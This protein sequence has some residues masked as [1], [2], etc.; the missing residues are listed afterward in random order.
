MIIGID[1]DNTLIDYRN[2]FWFTALETGTLLESERE[3]ITENGNPIPSKN[4]IKK[5][6]LSH[7]N[8]NYKWEYLQGQVY[9]NNIHHAQI[10]PGVANFLLHC[11]RRGEKVFLISHKTEY[12]H[13]DKNKTSL[14][15]A[16]LNFL[17]TNYLFSDAF[18][19]TR[20]DIFFFDTRQKKVNKIAELNCDYFID[21]LSEVFEE[22][23]F[24]TGTK[25]ILFNIGSEQSADSSFN[26]WFKIN[27]FFFKRIVPADVSAYVK[28][29]INKD[30]K[31]IKKIKG[32]GN[33]SIFRIE[34]KSGERY[35]GKLYPDPTFDNRKRLEN[36]AKA[37]KFLH[38]NNINSVPQVIWTDDNLN[39]G[40]YEW[41]HGSEIKNISKSNISNAVAFVKSLADLSKKTRYEEFGLASAACISGKMIQ[42]QIH[43]RYKKISGFSHLYPALKDFLENELYTSIKTILKFSQKNWPG[44]FSVY[45]KKENQL[46]SPSDFGF[47]N[48]FQTDHGLWFIDFEYFGWDNP[49]KL[50]CDFILHPG[51]HLTDDQKKLWA[52]NMI[53]IFS[54]DP[55]FKQRLNASYCSYGL[56]WCL[57]LLNEFCADEI[58]KRNL[59]VSEEY[60]VTQKQAEQLL[61]SKAL[62]EHII[63]THK[64]GF[65]YE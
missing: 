60:N 51:M 33:S 37:C 11:R 13:Y 20:D 30:V 5:Y 58:E 59:A 39:F 16:A 12:G 49:V 46:L 54:N 32:R 23:D 25:K 29:G 36:E 28:K 42:D 43:E 34:M 4:E 38:S 55:T 7:E 26:S 41:I 9:G 53:N 31:S 44:D 15:E 64:S 45:L 35:V 56:C 10:F 47:H 62:L 40:L 63:N 3:D 19:M 6:L 24:P 65:P 48:A 52:E 14:R 50:T 27:E 57:I 61:K 21:D 22:P 8:G 2:A 18:D 17:E 1:L